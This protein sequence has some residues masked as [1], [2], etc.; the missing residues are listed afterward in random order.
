MIFSKRIKKEWMVLDCVT[1]VTSEVKGEPYLIGNREGVDFRIEG[2]P[3][4]TG[5]CAFTLQ[6]NGA[7]RV[8]CDG[9]IYIDENRAVE[10]DLPPGEDYALRIGTHLCYIYGGDSSFNWFASVDLNSWWVIDPYDEAIDG[11]KSM[12]VIIETAKRMTLRD[13]KK[14]RIMPTGTTKAF[15]IEPVQVNQSPNQ[16]GPSINESLAEDAKTCPHCWVKFELGEMMHVSM[17]DELRGDPILGE[18]ASQRFLASNFDDDGNALDPMG[19]PCM[20]TAC[21][22]CRKT[23]PVNF[24]SSEY[25]IVSVV[26][27]ASA[28]K[29]YYLA[30]MSRVLPRVLIGS[31]GIRMQDAD[32]TANAPLT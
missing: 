21:P 1:G 27:N 20:D 7:V 25:N 31:Y 24:V 2:S 12:E 18:D 19:L 32:P 17:H 4:M 28:G 9:Y 11:P 14:Y 13:G 6:K 23:L 15:D 8:K 30:V 22:H 10:M 26:G 16:Q 29:S 3:A 5:E